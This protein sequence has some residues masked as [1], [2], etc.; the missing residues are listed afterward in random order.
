MENNPTEWL[1]AAWKKVPAVR[2]DSHLL[3][4][5][6]RNTAEDDLEQRLLT[7]KML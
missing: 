2:E 5:S 6:A 3:H 1:S 4:D 7:W